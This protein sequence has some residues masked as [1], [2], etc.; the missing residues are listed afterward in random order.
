L[1]RVRSLPGFGPDVQKSDRWPLDTARTTSH[2]HTHAG[3]FQK[4]FCR[5]FQICPH[6]ENPEFSTDTL[7]TLD[8]CRP[9]NSGNHAKF[10]PGKRHECGR[11]TGTDDGVCLTPGME[12]QRDPEGG[13][14]ESTNRFSEG[15]MCA[16]GL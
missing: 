5:T 15:M 2:L 1:K 4:Q 3:E 9:R 14:G 6:I 10:L 7:Q 12:S 13:L 8:D 16:N 11:I